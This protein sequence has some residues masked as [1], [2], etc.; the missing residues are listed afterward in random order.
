MALRSDGRAVG[1]GCGTN[2]TVGNGQ[3]A[4]GNLPNSFVML[5]RKIVDFSSSGYCSAGD[6]IV[7]AHHF[8]TTD[9]RV[10]TTGA[11]SNYMNG[12][13]LGNPRNTPSQIIF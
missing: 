9:G 10:Y 8:L 5:D 7:M 11:A 6:D 12:D 4:S 2:G 13:P 3:G 1:W